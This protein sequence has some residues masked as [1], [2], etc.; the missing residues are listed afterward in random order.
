MKY[1]HSAPNEEEFCNAMRRTFPT[2]DIV[3]VR[4]IERNVFTAELELKSHNLLKSCDNVD[5]RYNTQVP[6]DIMWLDIRT[7]ELKDDFENEIRN[8]CAY[9]RH[10]DADMVARTL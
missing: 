1:T 8:W 9:C 5:H 7:V 10:E 6:R 3:A 2:C 4:R